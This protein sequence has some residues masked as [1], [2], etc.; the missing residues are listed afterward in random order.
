MGA[1]MLFAASFTA[2]AEK[3]YQKLVE[4]Y[5]VSAEV[6]NL[7]KNTPQE[8][9]QII[10]RGTRQ[11]LKFINSNEGKDKIMKKAQSQIENIQKFYPQYDESVIE[12]AQSYCDSLLLRMGI[13]KEIFGK[14]CTLHI[15]NSYDV[16]AF[17]ALTEDGFA[18]CLTTAL[19]RHKG[20]NDNIIMGYI[21][22]EYAHGILM[23][24][25]KGYYAEFK[26]E[27]RNKVVAG[28]TMAVSAVGDGLGAYSAGM[29][30]ITYQPNTT[31]EFI[32]NIQRQA[33]LETMLYALSFQCEQEFEA[34]LIAYRFME[35]LGLGEESING[36]RILSTAYDSL[37]DSLYSDHPSTTDRINFLKF[38][39]G[40]PQYE[41]KI[42]TE[43]EE[44]EID[45]YIE[46]IW[47]T[48][49]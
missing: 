33:K 49:N 28:I 2:K 32:V 35:N 45:N 21:A 29:A 34:D 36:L 48:G 19:I 9:W 10:S 11:Y 43:K 38:V 27:R 7:E 4:N 26:K 8:F 47:S 5:D 39:Q 37:Y 18:I 17:C 15:V 30:G 42:I 25:L 40:N 31:P 3:T 6:K 46:R 12:Q 1:I 20:V 14:K 24:H 16:N 22:H 41:K 23:H 44:E 13:P